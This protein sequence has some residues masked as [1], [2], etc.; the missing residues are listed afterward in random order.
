MPVEPIRPVANMSRN[1]MCWCRSGKKWK[2][3]HRDRELMAPANIFEIEDEFQRIR[4]RGYCSYP[5]SSSDEC[6]QSITNAHTVQRRGGLSAIAEDGHVL[7]VQPTMKRMVANE[8]MPSPR[9]IGIGLAS[10]FPGFCNKHD[11]IAFQLIEGKCVDLNAGSALRFSYRAIAFE[12]FRKAAALEFVDP[13]RQMDRGQPLWRQGA[14]QDHLRCYEGGLRL[15]MRDLESCKAEYDSR[16]LSGNPTGFKFCAIRFDRLLPIVG[17]GAFHPEFDT[18]GREL[19]RLGRVGCE[20]QMLAINVTAFEQQTVVCFG[21]LR[22]G[23]DPA[24]NF[25]ESLKALP[26]PRVANAIVRVAFEHI[27]N[28]YLQQ[29]WW[30]SL[31]IADQAELKK[32]IWSGGNIVIRASDCLVDRGTIYSDAQVLEIVSE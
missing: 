29:S 18:N 12:R 23:T 5:K 30:D 25:V 10:T 11:R 21:W 4:K 27:E 26:S 28:I 31:S 19:Q 20:Y 8:G 2:K 7:A 13:M 17:C 15:G 24:Q 14:I 3:C 32:R 1:A 9:R 6:D 22:G 16:L